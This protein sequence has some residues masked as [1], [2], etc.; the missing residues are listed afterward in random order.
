MYRM[1]CENLKEENSWKFC[2]FLIDPGSAF[3]EI[4]R[5]KATESSI[6]SHTINNLC[7]PVWWLFD[8]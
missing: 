7:F 2:T 4:K 8:I 1:L 3:H 5:K 6:Q